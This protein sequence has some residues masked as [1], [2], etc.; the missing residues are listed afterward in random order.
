MVANISIMGSGFTICVGE[1]EGERERKRERE[2]ET[3]KGKGDSRLKGRGGK[4]REN[5]LVEN[6]NTARE[7]ET[8][9]GQQR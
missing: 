8:G 3:S 9:F 5:N 7:F 4:P 6:T 1:R 2:R